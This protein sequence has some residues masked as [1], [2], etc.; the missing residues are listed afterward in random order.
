M[1]SSYPPSPPFPEAV[2]LDSLWTEPHA[3]GGEF[4]D[5][6]R[7]YV[8]VT[9]P[10]ES[11]NYY[12]YF[13]QTNDEPY[14][15]GPFSVFDDALVNGQNFHF[16]LD[17]G[18]PKGT[19]FDFDTA[20][21]FEYGDWVHIKWCTIDKAAYDFWNTLEYSANSAGPL[22]AAV[23]VLTNIEG[24]LGNWTGYGAMEYEVYIE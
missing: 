2:P 19:E 4:I 7:L 20:G 6:L 1:G 3:G 5:Y 23:E 11:G 17:K 12:R 24:G 21:Y 22:G 9:D 15:P 18:E 10:P 8:E 16:P 13:T 14:Y